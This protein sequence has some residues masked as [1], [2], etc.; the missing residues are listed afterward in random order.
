MKILFVCTHNRCRSILAEA[1]FNHLSGAHIEAFSAGSTPSGVVHPLALS[2]LASRG[3]ATDGLQSQ[4]WDEYAGMDIEAVVTLCDSA[5]GESCPLWM[6]NAQ[7]I[8]WGLPDPSAI[9]GT[10]D[11]IAAA[12][13]TVITALNDRITFVNNQIANDSMSLPEAL[14]AAVN[15][16]PAPAL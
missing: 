14:K 7:K 6:G 16:H 1:I 5:A 3:I 10:D 12:F 4:S 11:E 2:N 9:S 8:H 13:D 15:Q